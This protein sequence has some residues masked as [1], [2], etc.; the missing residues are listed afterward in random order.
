MVFGSTT[1]KALREE[2]DGQ[3]PNFTGLGGYPLVY[4]TADGLVICPDCANETDTSD[5]V[6]AVDVYYE[7]PD[8]ACDDC[9]KA[10]KSAYGDPEEEDR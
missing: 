7:G 1:I 3:L 4:F 8:V 6:V 2:N 10:I 9:G 5:P